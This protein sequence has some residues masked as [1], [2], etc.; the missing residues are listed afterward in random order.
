MR[1]SDPSWSER[2]RGVESAHVDAD[3]ERR[4]P[5]GPDRRAPGARGEPET[6]SGT[7]RRRRA[8]SCARPRSPA[9]AVPSCG[10]SGSA[11]SPATRRSARTASGIQQERHHRRRDPGQPPVRRRPRL[12]GPR[13]AAR[14]PTEFRDFLVHFYEIGAQTIL[15]HDGLV[16]KLVGDE[17]IGLFFGG[18]TGP[19]HAAAAIAAAVDARGTAGRPNATPVGPIPLG[20]AV[21]TGMAYVGPTGPDRRGRRLHGARRRG[22]HHRPAGV[23]GRGRRAVLVSRRRGGGRRRHPAR[24]RSAGRSM[25]AGARRRSTWSCMP[26]RPADRS[27]LRSGSVPSTT[28]V[29]LRRSSWTT[30]RHRPLTSWPMRSLTPTGGSRRVRGARGWRRFRRARRRGASRSRRPPRPGSAPRAALARRPDRGR[31]P[32]RRRSPRRRP[33]RPAGPSSGRGAT[34]PRTGPSRRRGLAGDE[35]GRLPGAI[36]RSDPSRAPRARASRRR[37]RS[38]PR[39]CAGRPASRR[40]VIGSMRMSTRQNDA[41]RR[42]SLG[43]R[44]TPAGG[45]GSSVRG[46]SD[47]VGSTTWPRPGRRSPT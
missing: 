37:S 30:S 28:D 35:A 25:S 20:A 5:G 7:S 26:H 10:T 21:H 46:E 9:P 14:R 12:D 42:R 41:A 31:P 13:R 1:P 40:R 39:R 6:C 17:V 36:G 29:R 4:V 3:V 11:G 27:S 24:T 33:R 18:V 19:H 23:R 22:Q 43:R 47:R 2:R 34:Q 8:A 45:P 15:D 16:D 32:R 44:S 38:P